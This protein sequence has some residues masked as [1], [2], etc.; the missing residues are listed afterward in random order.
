MNK[1]F[2]PYP[3]YKSLPTP[4]KYPKFEGEQETTFVALNIYESSTGVSRTVKFNLSE[5]INTDYSN[6]EKTVTDKKYN[7]LFQ[8][9]VNEIGYEKANAYREAIEL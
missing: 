4:D 2:I 9:L 8:V 1:T 5:I 7:D 6:T 3:E